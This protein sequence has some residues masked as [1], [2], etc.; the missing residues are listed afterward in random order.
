MEALRQLAGLLDR[1]VMLLIGLEDVPILIEAECLVEKPVASLHIAEAVWIQG[2]IP[3]TGKLP[4]IVQHGGEAELLGLGGENV[5]EGHIVVQYMDGL[6]ILHWDEKDSVPNHFIE[7]AL[8]GQ[9][10]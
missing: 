7:F 2:L 10:A 4:A 5:E 8:K 1:A 3:G 6:S 9:A